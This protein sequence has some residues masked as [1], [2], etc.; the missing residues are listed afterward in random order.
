MDREKVNHA[1]IEAEITAQ[2]TKRFVGRTI[3]AVGYLSKQEAEDL[4]W[5]E[6]PLAFQLDNGDWIYPSRDPEGNDAGT[7]F[8]NVEELPVI[9]SLGV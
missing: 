8:T 2:A 3:K 9:G 4:G 1:K 5:S 7:L 6:R